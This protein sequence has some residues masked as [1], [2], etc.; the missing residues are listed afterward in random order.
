[1]RFDKENELMSEQAVTGAATVSSNSY[2]K[3]SAD[4]D[5]A[6][7]RRMALLFYF[8]AAGAGTTHTLSVIEADV[9]ALTTNKEVLASV[10]IATADLPADKFVEVPIPPRKMN[11]LHLGAQHSATGGTTTATLSCWLVPQ[12][13]IPYYKSFPKLNDVEF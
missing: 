5:I 9:T 4:Q 2:Q 13:E 6:I 10:S 3:A 8:H 1:M 12:D 11:Q 7:G